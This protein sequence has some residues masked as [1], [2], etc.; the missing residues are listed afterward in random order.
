MLEQA[1]IDAD[2]LR[3]H[4]IKLAEQSLV[5]KHADELKKTMNKLLEQED[6][7]GG[8]NPPEVPIMEMDDESSENKISEEIKDQIPVAGTEML[9]ENEEELE[10]DFEVLKNQMKDQ[11]IDFQNDVN[12]QVS[13]N[14]QNV[15]TFQGSQGAQMGQL[16][17]ELSEDLDILSLFEGLEDEDLEESEHLDETSMSF[18]FELKPHGH[19]GK[20]TTQELEYANDIQKIKDVQ[21]L[22][23]KIKFLNQKLKESTLKIENLES[24]NH[25][26]NEKFLRLKEQVN[27]VNISNC[28]LL[29][30]NKILGS[31]SLNER[32]KSTMIEKI[33]EAKTVGEAKV[34]F[35]T[36]KIA[37]EGMK[38]PSKSLNESLKRNQTLQIHPK[39]E[40]SNSEDLK[41][42]EIVKRMQQLAG[43]KKH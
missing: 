36:L 15:P 34:I 11:N 10:I 33:S 4:A 20:L 13:P 19:I 32:Q 21:K 16:E 3:K 41:N 7:F 39:L 6:L 22:Q 37:V 1:I 38:K 26:Q 35:E 43:I 14:A 25:L 40:N 42:N 27:K 8:S 29:L 9:E 30:S 12:L 23:E 28:K 31:D 5:K 2:E 18:D 17:E 24:Y